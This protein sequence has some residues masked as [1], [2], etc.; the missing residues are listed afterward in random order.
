MPR[1]PPD[2]QFPMRALDIGQAIKK[3]EVKQ[4]KLS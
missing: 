3:N 4:Q 2:M 1:I